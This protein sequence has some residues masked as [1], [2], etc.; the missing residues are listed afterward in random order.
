LVVVA[1][2]RRGVAETVGSGERTPWVT[3]LLLLLRVVIGGNGSFIDIRDFKTVCYL[4]QVL[5]LDD[6]GTFS[7]PFGHV[8]SVSV[9]RCGF[10]GVQT[11]TTRKV[12]VGRSANNPG[13]ITS[14][15]LGLFSTAI[16]SPAVFLPSE[17]SRTLKTHRSTLPSFT[18]TVHTV[19]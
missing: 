3:I 6:V 14:S 18:S 8:L 16:P 19:I 4:Y 11:G 15:G 13:C 9:G 12:I 2:S 10:G 5:R 17:T 1:V 7:T